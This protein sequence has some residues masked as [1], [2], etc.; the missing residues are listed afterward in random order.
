[1]QTATLITQVRH[2][3]GRGIRR[4]AVACDHGVSE[5]IYQTDAL[6]WSLRLSEWDAERMVV[7]HHFAVERCGCTVALRSRYAL[8]VH[9]PATSNTA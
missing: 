2:G 9:E 1:M 7:A 4:L 5:F 3:L 8:S 6:P